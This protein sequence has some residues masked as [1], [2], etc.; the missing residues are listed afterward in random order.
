MFTDPAGRIAMLTYVLRT[1]RKCGL[2]Q[3][4][5][6][7]VAHTTYYSNLKDLVRY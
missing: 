6:K 5:T 1:I 4:K 3:I 7:M 2:Y